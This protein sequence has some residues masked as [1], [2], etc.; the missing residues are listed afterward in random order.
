MYHSL[1][2]IARIASAQ[3][4]SAE[5]ERLDDIIEVCTVLYVAVLALPFLDNI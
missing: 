3:N 5:M 4:D 2:S 1:Y